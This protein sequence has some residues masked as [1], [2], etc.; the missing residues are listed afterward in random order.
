MDPDYLSHVGTYCR[1]PKPP[2]P[3]SRALWCVGRVLAGLQGDY[4]QKAE[5]APSG[6]WAELKVSLLRRS[7]RGLCHFKHL[8]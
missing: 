3:A 4:L 2:R 5:C 1:S 8:P 6:W 7:V